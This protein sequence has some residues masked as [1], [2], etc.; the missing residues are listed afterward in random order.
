MLIVWKVFVSAISIII[1]TGCGYP[2]EPSPSSQRNFTSNYQPTLMSR[3]LLENS[4]SIKNSSNIYQAGKIYL[5]KNYIFINEK[6]KG[7][8]IIDN[9]N[10][11][12]PTKIGFIAIA[13][14][15]DMAIKNDVI[16][17]DNSTDLVANNAKDIN[18]IVETKRFRSTFPEPIAPDGGSYTK[19][20]EEKE[21]N[22]TGWTLRE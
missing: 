15:L 17:V 10:G 4:V 1:L 22:I 8:H 12:L 21:A 3:Q 16:Y 9:T 14:S 13:G 11:S 19:S 2:Q 6:Y 18:N 20:N 5:Y 7:F